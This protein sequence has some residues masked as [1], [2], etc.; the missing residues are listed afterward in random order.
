MADETCALDLRRIQHLDHPIGHLRHRGKRRAGRLAMPGQVEREHVPAVIAKVAALQA[1][2]GVVEAGA[3]DEHDRA[4][5]RVYLVVRGIS[6]RLG[7]LHFWETFRERSR[8][9]IRSCGSSRPTESRTV[10]AVMP[11]FFRSSSL[12]L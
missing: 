1:E 10:P 8:S 9:S 6:E 7:D 11:A 3:V 5:R 2:P 12:M 4:L